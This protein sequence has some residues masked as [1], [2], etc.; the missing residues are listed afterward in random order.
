MRTLLGD[1]LLAALVGGISPASVRRYAEGTRQTPDGVAWRLHAVARILSGIMGSYNAYGARRWFERPRHA[2]DDTT[3]LQVFQSALNED[4]P[5]LQTL[6]DTADGA[7]AEFLRHEEITEP[8]DL[9]GIERSLWAVAPTD[10]SVSRP[11]LP[12]KVQVGDEHLPCQA[13]ARRMRSAGATALRAAQAAL[14]PGGAR[15]QRTDGGLQEGN[16]RDGETLVLFE[17]RPSLTGWRIVDAGR[18]P[19]RILPLVRH[20]RHGRARRSPSSRRKR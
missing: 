1:S 2:L 11:R 14:I 4:D 19:T 7:W 8:D 16:A 6:C 13:E 3:P 17:R 18:P 20:L 10:E 9:A 12:A 15:G 5:S